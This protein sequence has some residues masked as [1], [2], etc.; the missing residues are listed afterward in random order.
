MGTQSSFI[1]LKNYLLTIDYL[2]RLFEE[3][4]IKYKDNPFIASRVNSV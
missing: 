3:A 1:T 2:L 4:K